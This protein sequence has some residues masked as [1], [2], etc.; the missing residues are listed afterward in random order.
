MIIRVSRN[1]FISSLIGTALGVGFLVKYVLRLKVRLPLNISSQYNL[2]ICFRDK[3]SGKKYTYQTDVA[4]NK[5]VIITGASTG[6][7]KAIAKDLIFRKAVVILA[8]RDME[9]CENVCSFT[10]ASYLFLLY[11]AIINPDSLY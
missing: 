5:V 7:G 4:K 2:E 9:K 3:F 8:C 6:L 1:A 10:L 11:I